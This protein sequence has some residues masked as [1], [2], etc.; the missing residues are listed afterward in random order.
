MTENSRAERVRPIGFG[1]RLGAIFIDGFVLLFISF[2]VL[3]AAGIVLTLLNAYSYTSENPYPADTLLLLIGLATSIL[4]YV[5]F[6]TKSGVTIGKNAVGIKVVGRDGQPLSVGRALIRYAG[7]IISGVVLALG[8]L[9]ILFDRRRQGWHDKLAGSFVI[10][11]D[12]DFTDAAA[13]EFVTTGSGAR[14]AWVVLWIIIA[15]AA[16]AAFLLSIWFLG[17][18]LRAVITDLLQ[19]LL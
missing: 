15:L 14:W 13:A 10:D 12:D 4:Y 5:G 16:P 11:V 3:F 7:Y 2:I 6:W 8:F 18:S 1:K 17:P 19:S 9:W